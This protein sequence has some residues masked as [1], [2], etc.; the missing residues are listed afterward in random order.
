MKVALVVSLLV[1]LT[2]AAALYAA[3]PILDE[4]KAKANPVIRHF[5]DALK[6]KDFE[7]AR[8]DFDEK[9][10]QAVPAAMLKDDYE[11]DLPQCGEL[12]SWDYAGWMRDGGFDTVLVRA[13]CAKGDIYQYKFAFPAGPDGKQLAGL[14][15]KPVPKTLS[16]QEADAVVKMFGAIAEDHLKAVMAKDYKAAA[17]AFSDEM[18]KALGPDKLKAFFDEQA[19]RI[20]E[21]AL[22]KFDC[23]K[24][25]APDSVGLYYHAT[26]SR[27]GVF[28]YRVVFRADGKDQK[29]QGV[30]LKPP[31]EE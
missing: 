5:F 22:W 20:G 1:V 2:A 19:I 7:G 4:I 23:A 21:L 30:W 18:L 9:L 29:I 11:K 14:W 10:A 31:A 6:A 12:T 16:K 27:G 25:L 28:S 24:R 8:K 15:K 13:R 17:A 26:F 3:D